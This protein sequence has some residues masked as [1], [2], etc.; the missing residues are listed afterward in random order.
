MTMTAGAPNRAVYG[1]TKAAV[2]GLTK[3]IA[4]D[5]ADKNIRLD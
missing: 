5:F 2:I 1:A 3:S 4:A